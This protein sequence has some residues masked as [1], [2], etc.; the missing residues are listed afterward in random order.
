MNIFYLDPNPTIAARYHVDKHVVKMILESAQILST[1][2]HINA[3]DKRILDNIYRPTHY[4]HPSTIW[5][6]QNKN[7]YR[8]LFLLFAALLDEY[9]FRFGKTH[10]SSTLIDFLKEP[11]ESLSDDPFFPP[12]PAME[13]EYLINGD[14]LLSYR[15]YY[16]RAKNHLFH[17][18][19]RSRPEWLIK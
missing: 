5:A 17:W 16:L 18:T 10:K 6:S 11:P 2:H 1:V 8:W 15:N 3:S 13:D 12:T 7:N 4:H 9:T 19:K 14:S